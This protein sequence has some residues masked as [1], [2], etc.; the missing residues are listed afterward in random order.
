MSFDFVVG[1]VGETIAAGTVIGGLEMLNQQ[2]T[3]KRR[4]APEFD[5]EIERPRR[6]RVRRRK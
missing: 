2:T 4:K 5:F 1:A 6:H 3:R